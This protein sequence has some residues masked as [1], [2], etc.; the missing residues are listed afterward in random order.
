MVNKVIRFKCKGVEYDFNT[1]M[2]M[3]R[4]V[5]GYWSAFEHQ[6]ECVKDAAINAQ[7]LKECLL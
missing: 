5:G 3:I 7:K 4:R 1:Q 2:R 6:W